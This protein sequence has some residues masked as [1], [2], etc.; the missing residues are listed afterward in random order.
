MYI[1]NIY[2]QKKAQK[3]PLSLQKFLTKA[4]KSMS[5]KTKEFYLYGIIGRY[6][7]IDTNIL[8][9]TIESFRK[10]GVK[11]FVFYVNSD[12]GEVA[13]GNTLYNYLDRTDIEVEWIVDGIAASMMAV[14]LSNP[15]HKVKAAKHAK[16]MY[17]RVSGYTYGNSDETRAS[18]DMMDGFETTLIEMLAERMHIGVEDVRKKFFDGIDHWVSAKEAKELGLCDEIITRNDTIKELKTI[19]D[20]RSA[21]NYYNK[22]IINLNQSKKMDENLKK[23]ANILDMSNASEQEVVSQVQS[24]SNEK[25]NL[26]NSL[27]AEKQKNEELSKKIEAMEKS[28][29]KNLIDAAIADKR[30]GED[31]RETYT[32]LAEQDYENTEKILNKMQPVGRVKNAIE[33]NGGIPKGEE[34][35]GFDEYHK[36]GKLENL[37][38]NNPERYAELFEA[39]FGYSPKN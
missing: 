23:V 30:I 39:K 36:S 37:K 17:H 22:Q 21:F 34:N 12:G 14:L 13:Q 2:K 32:K 4:K 16:F 18:A 28:K 1:T 35:W 24:I 26:Q 9:Q 19:T 38:I 15:K 10:S 8:I 33:Q 5:D 11:K 6:L 7:D 20:S 29:V 3:K 27:Q 31:D 25:V